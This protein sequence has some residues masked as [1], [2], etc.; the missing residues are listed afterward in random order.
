MIRYL[1]RLFKA[2]VGQDVL[3]IDLE[4]SEDQVILKINERQFDL[5][6]MLADNGFVIQKVN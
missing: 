4:M 5:T 1:M 6:K 2:L 3:H